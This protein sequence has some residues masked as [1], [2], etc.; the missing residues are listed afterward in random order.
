[1]NAADLCYMP[2][3]ELAA[4]YRDRSIS[5]VEVV[6]AVLRRIETLDPRLNALVFP[7]ADE[8]RA[9]ARQAEQAIMRGDVLGAMHGIPLTIKDTQHLT[10]H[11]TQI[12]SPSRKGLVSTFTA[13]QAQRMIDAGAIVI[14]KTTT[15]EFGWKGVSESPLTGITHNPWKQGMNAGASSAGAAVAAAAGYAPLNQGGDGAG[16]IRMPAHFSGVYGLKPTYGRVPNYPPPASDHTVH[17][18]PLTRTVADSALML[19]TMAGPHPWD[20]HSLESPPADYTGRLHEPL[21]M[22]KIAF[23]AD[24]GHARVDP[25]VAEIVAA[26]VKR[27][28]QDLKLPVTQITPDWGPRGPE[29]IRYFWPAHFTQYAALLERS[30]GQMDQGLAACIREGLETRVSEYVQKRIA[31]QDYCLAIHRSFEDWDFLLTPAVSVAAFPADRLQPAHWPQ[32]DWDWIMW[33]EFSYPFNMSGNP[34]ASIPCG[35]TKDGLPVGLQ[36]VGRRFDDL[37][38]L[39]LSALFEA[40]QPWADKRPPLD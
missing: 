24:L 15:P 19:K 6:D 26:A 31:K 22:P 13:P 29:L 33:A 20:M 5:P 27:F 39:K 23:S 16:S 36:I 18:G 25:E 9:Q 38:V 4:R 21:G 28:E 12:G 17:N 8:A 1:M 10:G 14:G 2:A 40:A 34:A 32:H 7:L 37:G 30:P 35:F 11:P 3:T